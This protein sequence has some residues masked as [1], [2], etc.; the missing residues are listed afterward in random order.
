MSLLCVLF[1]VVCDCVCE[2]CDVFI[3]VCVVLCILDFD[4]RMLCGVLFVLSVNGFGLFSVV[5]LYVLWMCVML[6]SKFRVNM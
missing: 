5:M 1:V 6:L 2:V 3:G 4:V